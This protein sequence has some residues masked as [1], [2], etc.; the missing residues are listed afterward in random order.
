LESG[1]GRDVVTGEQGQFDL[2]DI[3]FSAGG[4]PVE[5]RRYEMIR[6]EGQWKI[7]RAFKLVTSA[8][9][10]SNQRGELTGVPTSTPAPACLQNIP[11][12]AKA[13]G[14]YIG[15]INQGQA[16]VTF[17]AAGSSDSDGAIQTYSWG[18][19]DGSP[20]GSGQS[21]DHN[22]TRPGVY[23]ATLTVIDNCGIS[24]QDTA[25][26]TIGIPK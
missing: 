17:S 8:A 2:V 25:T 16:V 19:G 23:T 18:F 7:N 14:P 6:V 11:P 20:L 10:S 21:V 26:V 4:A 3:S 13:D 12:V 22:Y 1:G 24:S 15:L 5:M 9:E